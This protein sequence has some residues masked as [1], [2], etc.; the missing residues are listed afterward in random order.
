MIK[1][2]ALDLDNTLLNSD[3]KISEANTAA[4]KKLH[5][6]GKA[7]VL[8]TGR[9]INAIW[10]WLKQLGLMNE[11]DYSVNFNG[12]LVIHNVDKKP[13]M[14]K[15]MKRDHFTHLHEFCEAHNYPL[16]ILD[17]N[18]VY[19]IND[20]PLSGYEKRL[21]GNMHFLH[22]PFAKIPDV[23][24]SKAVICTEPATL[25]K[26]VAEMPAQLSKE[27]HIV[28]SQPMILEFLKPGIDKGSALDVLL[29]H[30]GW[31]RE[32]LMTF[33]DA[34]NDLEMLASAGVGV[35]MANG[36][37]EAKKTANHVTVLDNNH[38]GVADFLKTYFAK[39]E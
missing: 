36:T 10:D 17:F 8:C 29:D 23:D 18:G 35:S 38:D 9:P 28:R 25:D 7:V 22:V 31:T 14:E 13:L 24:Y 6:A 4:L 27:F 32:N 34:E 16:D 26:I 12:S 33:G 11:K 19:P 1:M 2:I 30:L 20:L 3:K 39:N 5:K 15:G 37:P 21:G